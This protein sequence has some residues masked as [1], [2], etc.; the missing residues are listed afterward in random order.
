MQADEIRK[1]EFECDSGQ[2][3]S[4]FWLREIAAQL[5]ELN[6]HFKKQNEQLRKG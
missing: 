2:W 6:E 4:A 3:E 5:A 1:K